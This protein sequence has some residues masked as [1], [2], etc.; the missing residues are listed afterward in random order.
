[1][2]VEI[3]STGTELLLGQIINT[4][5]PYLARRL[6]DLGYD[7][8]YQ[9]TVGDNKERMT[10]VIAAALSRADIVFVTGGLGPTNGDISKTVTAKLLNKQLLL[11]KP[12]VKKIKDFFYTRNKVMTENNLRQAM[13]PEGGIVLDNDIGTAPG[14]III[15]GCKLII[16]LPGPP[17]ELEPMFEKAA[18]V[19][20]QRVGCQGIILSRVLCTH[21]IGEA[22]LEE[23]IRGFIMHQTNPT[24]ALLAKNSKIH[25]R[26]T[27]KAAAKDAAQVLLDKLESQLRANI[28]QY[29]VGIKAERVE[30]SI[31]RLLSSKELTLALAESCTGGL[32]TSKLT[33]VAGS[34]KYLTG[35]IVCYSNYIKH[36]FVGVPQENLADF[37]AV[38]PETAECMAKNIRGKF[39][40]AIG[41]GITGIAGPEGGSQGKPV[42]LVY[43]AVDG[44]SGCRLYKHKFTGSRE[45]I[46]NCAAQ[47]ALYTL[48][49]YVKLI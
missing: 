18:A 30:E 24:I 49:N 9:S 44:P 16:H 35:S 39:G 15:S 3:V 4:T 1:M 5:A 12:S 33:D 2:I 47:T 23:K 6:N 26:L 31:G 7:T 19:L 48:W 41:L 42:G 25:V 37:G 13:L 21:G 8:L 34:S 40:T 36:N 32:I 27:A 17:G 46:K 10:Q 20:E 38:S 29:I 22:E 43:M 28:D 11:H 14:V 45:I